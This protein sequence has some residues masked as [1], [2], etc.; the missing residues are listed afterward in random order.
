M[1]AP[2]F[3]K[4]IIKDKIWGR[5]KWM[6]SARQNESSIIFPESSQQADLYD[7]VNQYPE[8]FGM[9]QG[10]T[11]PLL[12]KHIA[13]HD[14]LSVQVHPDDDYA[15]PLHSTG[16][17]ECWYILSAEEG[18]EI[19]Y[20]HRAKDKDEFIQM[21]QEERW[22]MLL[23]RKKVKAGDFIY[24]PSGTLHAIGKGIE[25]IEV[26]QNSDITYRAFDYH[27]TDD[28][29]QLRELHLD[30]VMNTTQIPHQENNVIPIQMIKDG[31]KV[32]T[33]IH[34]SF[35]TV[36][37]FDIKGVRSMEINDNYSINI[38]LDGKGL[39]NID[40]T[41]YPLEKDDVFVLPK[42][43]RHVRFLNDL[44]IMHVTP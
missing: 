1:T 11:F 35:F 15:K 10:N 37:T 28:S 5:E 34:N 36:K 38:V 30:D 40:G 16:K 20:G 3:L 6:V 8:W 44:K 22:D 17:T 43:V 9:K 12:I 13:T 42:G 21:V 4:S 25:L 31:M 32:T 14:D 23:K 27:R 41:I 19:V 29:G 39:I 24:V 18:A 7:I 33:Y 26:Q 2:I